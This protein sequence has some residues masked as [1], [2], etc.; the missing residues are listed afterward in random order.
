MKIRPVGAEL[1]H[2]DGQ[3]DRQ[4]DRQTN[5]RTDKKTDGQTDRQ[6]DGWTDKRTDGRTDRQTN[7]RMDKRTDGQ[8]DRQT[9]G[10]MDGQT[11]GRRDRQTEGRTD[12]TNLTI[13]LRNFANELKVEMGLIR[14]I[15][16]LS[17]IGTELLIPSFAL[18]NPKH[19]RAQ[20]CSHFYFKTVRHLI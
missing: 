9:N 6:T 14:D 3:T 19:Q 7:G 8:T 1:F 10:R 2:G 4:T 11:D 20:N 5:V 13:A 18:Y 16:Y 17:A 15:P 12:M